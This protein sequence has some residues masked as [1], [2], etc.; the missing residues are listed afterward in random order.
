MVVD[1]YFIT[2]N[3]TFQRMDIQ[4]TFIGNCN[5]ILDVT[6]V[7]AASPHYADNPGFKKRLIQR[8]RK[9]GTDSFIV[10]MLRFCHFCSIQCR[11]TEHP[12]TFSSVYPKHL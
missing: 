3:S 1:F 8:R 7:I 6:I 5:K 11:I 2:R 4:L 10:D 9:L 12:F